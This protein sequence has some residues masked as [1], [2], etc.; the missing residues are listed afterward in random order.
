MGA[1]RSIRALFEPMIGLI[2][3]APATAFVPLLIIW[4]GLVVRHYGC[5]G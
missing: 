4:L 5:D 2:R 3:Y 1:F